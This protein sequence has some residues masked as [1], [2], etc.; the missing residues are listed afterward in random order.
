MRQNGLYPGTSAFPF[1]LFFQITWNSITTKWKVPICLHRFAIHFSMFFLI[2]IHAYS[3]KKMSWCSTIWRMCHV[4]T[5]KDLKK[6]TFEK[7]A[8]MHIWQL[9]RVE[10]DSI[11][12]RDIW[13]ARSNWG[14]WWRAISEPFETTKCFLLCCSV[15]ALMCVWLVAGRSLNW[16]RRQRLQRRRNSKLLNKTFWLLTI[17]VNLGFTS[18]LEFN[19]DQKLS[20]QATRC[21]MMHW[22]EHLFR[23]CINC[24]RR[25]C[26]LNLTNG[27][28]SDGLTSIFDYPVS[29]AL[30]ARRFCAW[31]LPQG[32]G[33]TWLR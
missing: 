32:L 5:V 8:E 30:Q 14:T 19:R 7:E 15:Y 13:D 2:F 25:F 28:F 4:L 16:P 1:F 3:L 33:A 31:N 23:K 12:V 29:D 27:F 22:T 10:R 9:R 11:R 24:A 18:S 20:M 6:A 21:I 17:F 26:L